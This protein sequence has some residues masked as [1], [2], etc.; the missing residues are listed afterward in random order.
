[1]VI[2]PAVLLLV[3][4]FFMGIQSALFGPVKYSILPDH[5]REEELLGDNGQMAAGTFVAILLGTILGGL[6][7]PRA[8]AVHPK[9][10]RSWQY[11]PLDAVETEGPEARLMADIKTGAMSA[12]R[13]LSVYTTLVYHRTGSY[14][15]T[16]RR[17][18]MDR[19]T[20]R[21]RVDTALL[22]AL[23]EHG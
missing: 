22:A 12:E 10:R 1:M 3:I 2:N 8:G 20:V 4:L 15:A 19:R 21:A 5:L 18:G 7:V 14:Q 11:R 9:R 17:I 6:A 13:L 16:A 23:E